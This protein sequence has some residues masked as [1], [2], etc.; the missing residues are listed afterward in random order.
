MSKNW[1]LDNE[2]IQKFNQEGCLK[3]VSS[4]TVE[5]DIYGSKREGNRNT[6]ILGE[7]K[8][9]DKPINLKEFK[10]F[11]LKASIIA[12]QE[13]THDMKHSLKE[14]SFH[15]VVISFGG[16]SNS[17]K[18]KNLLKEDKVWDLAQNRILDLE[19]ISK[20]YFIKLLKKNKIQIKFYK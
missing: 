20:N 18:M 10:C 13:K 9:R 1:V 4:R 12:N 3:D 2:E 7:C 11:L 14:P 8:Y 6:Y 16:F 15:L 5:L 17:D 19:L